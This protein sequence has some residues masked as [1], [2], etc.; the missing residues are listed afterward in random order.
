[1]TKNN[2]GM[3]H[4]RWYKTYKGKIYR[5]TPT[6]IHSAINNKAIIDSVLIDKEK[7]LKAILTISDSFCYQ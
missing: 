5:N 3:Y 4:D 1:M 6:D 7:P 2:L